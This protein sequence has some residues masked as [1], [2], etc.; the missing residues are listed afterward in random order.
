MRRAPLLLATGG[1]FLLLHASAGAVPP[2]GD[3][4]RRR[5]DGF[6]L[7]E[8]AARA[9]RDLDYRGT[10]IVSFWSETGSSAAMIDVEHVGGRG[11]LMRVAPTPQNPGGAVYDDEAGEVPDAIGLGALGLLREQYEAAVEGP[12]TVAGRPADVVTV[13]RP[14]QGTAARFWIDRQTRLPLR[15]EVLDGAGR[16][17]KES[18]FLEVSVGPVRVAPDVLRI[19]QPMPLMNGVPADAGALRADGWHVPERL[20]TGMRL[21]DGR[22]SG[23]TLHLTY[24]D[25]LSSVSVFQQRGELDSAAVDGWTRADVGTH[26]VWVQDAF[27][28]RVVWAGAGTVFTVV[29]DC[30]QATLDDLVGTL[31]HGDPGP[32]MVTRLG[33]G[34]ARVGSWLNPFA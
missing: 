3:P 28:R 32:G 2:N 5:D 13:H 16:T 9:A 31:P 27:P 1:A 25:G 20:Q 7:L 18:A 6:T 26:A 19:A 21:I 12:G 24:S 33:N 15:R 8:Q 22:L 4:D 10:Q 14:G 23:E 11:L 17:I 34:L 30:P 29:A